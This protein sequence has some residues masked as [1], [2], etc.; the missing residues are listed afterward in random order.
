MPIPSCSSAPATGGRWPR[1]VTW[2]AADRRRYLLTPTEAAE[3]A[4]VFHI[5]AS[6][7]PPALRPHCRAAARAPALAHAVGS[8]DG[9]PDAGSSWTWTACFTSTARPLR[10]IRR[11]RRARGLGFALRFVTNTTSRSRGQ[12]LAKLERL[13]S[14]WR[15]TS[16]SRP[17]V[18]GLALPGARTAPGPARHERRGEGG[19][20][21]ARRGRR[22]ARS[23]G[24]RWRP[25]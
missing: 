24:D 9:R 12:T 25:W 18:R 13:G 6:A 16:W 8:R 19:L 20:C 3:R 2:L 23:R 15:P 22:G 1:A 11:S 10:C 5:D 7:P 14:R 17:L 21:R 4:N